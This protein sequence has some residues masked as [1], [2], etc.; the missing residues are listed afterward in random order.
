M[1]HIK[2]A[3]QEPQ[4]FILKGAHNC[5]SYDKDYIFQRSVF[6]GATSGSI[7]HL[8]EGFETSVTWLMKTLK[9]KRKH[10]NFGF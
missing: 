8:K 2:L 6:K 9:E 7:R 5:F 1:R 10:S 3:R 4:G